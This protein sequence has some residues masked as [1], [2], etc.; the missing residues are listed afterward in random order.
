MATTDSAARC[1]WVVLLPGQL[2][3][4]VCPECGDFLAVPM[5]QFISH[6]FLE[7]ALGFMIDH[8]RCDTTPLET[9]P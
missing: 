7:I 6:R 4:L 8:S 3:R 9:T 5:R 1:D 2:P